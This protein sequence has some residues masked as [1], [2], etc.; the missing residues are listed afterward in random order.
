MAR[1]EDKL[2]YMI[3]VKVALKI[4]DYMISVKVALKI[5]FC[6]TLKDR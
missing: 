3:S 6:S 4:T 1:N 5:I 2:D